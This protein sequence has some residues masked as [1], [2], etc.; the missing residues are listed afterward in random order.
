[1]GSDLRS[2]LGQLLIMGFED[3]AMSNALRA[4]LRAIEPGGVILFRRNIA[5]AKQTWELLRECQNAVAMPLFR[6]IDMEGGTVDRLRDTIA[7]A[8]AAAPVFATQQKKLYREHGRVIGEEVR[9]LGFNTDFAPSVDLA[10]DASAPVM[11]TRVVSSHAKQV[12]TYAG[13]FL[14]GLRDARVLGCGKHFPGLGEASL[15]THKELP[16]IKK[17]WKKLWDEDIYPYREL[18]REMPFVMVAHAAYPA[19]TKKG[20]PASLSDRWMREILRDKIGY[21]GLIVSDDLEM[22]GVQ[23]AAPI[24]EAAVETLR[25]GADMYLV[26]RNEEHVW[27][28]YEAVVREAERD[29]KFA[30]IAERVVDRVVKVKRGFRKLLPMSAAPTEKTV[31][32]LR[33]E[34]MRFGERV[35][36]AALV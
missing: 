13:E 4:V 29:R 12:V 17:A 21:R 35:E 15:D 25:A 9:A 5:D 1:M 36:K 2:R 11:T 30:A 18:R 8:A 27:S 24:E 16:S 10:F 34:L 26:C 7:P 31:A 19:V 33:K 20:V 32:R 23:A 14:R 3:A 22:G 28:T 6:C